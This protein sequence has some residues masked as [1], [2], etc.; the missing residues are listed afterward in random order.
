VGLLFEIVNNPTLQ[1]PLT[2]SRHFPDRNI[3]VFEVYVFAPP[4]PEGRGRAG[5]LAVWAD[6]GFSFGGLGPLK[7]MCL[8]TIVVGRD[9]QA[10]LST[11]SKPPRFTKP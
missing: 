6:A 7:F 4:P 5:A 3:V 11:I 9:W 2:P 1:I 10:G 8:Q